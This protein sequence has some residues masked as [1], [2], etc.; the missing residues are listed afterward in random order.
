MLR[1]KNQF[2]GIYCFAVLLGLAPLSIAQSRVSCD[3]LLRETIESMSLLPKRVRSLL[4]K[5]KYQEAAWLAWDLGY[6]NESLRLETNLQA[7]MER[8]PIIGFDDQKDASSDA[9]RLKLKSG[10]EGVWKSSELWGNREVANS[11]Y[12]RLFHSNLVPMT[13]RRKFQGEWGTFQYFYSDA[14]RADRADL[15][16]HRFSAD[17]FFHDFTTDQSDGHSEYGPARKNMNL[18]LTKRWREVLI[19]NEDSFTL[20]D[21]I[22]EK[23]MQELWRDQVLKPAKAFGL[24]MEDIRPTPK[25]LAEISGVSDKQIRKVLTRTIRDCSECIEQVIQRRAYYLRRMAP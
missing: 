8:D 16:K 9:Y 15:S 23:L 13:V 19:D 20:R 11:D 2:I 4:D 6:T 10:I 21:E 14:P 1:R 22:D 7:L 12:S 24:K 3:V 17:F 5:R 18:L 25:R